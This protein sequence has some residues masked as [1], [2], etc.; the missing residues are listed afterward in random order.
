MSAISKAEAYN[1]AFLKEEN[2]AIFQ[3]FLRLNPKVGHHFN[4]QVEEECEVSGEDNKEQLQV[5]TEDVC[6]MFEMRR[7]SLSWALLKNEMMDHNTRNF[8]PKNS[9]E[10]EKEFQGNSRWVHDWNWSAETKRTVSAQKVLP[11]M[12]GTRLQMGHCCRR[13]VEAETCYLCI[14]VNNRFFTKCETT[15]I[16][17]HTS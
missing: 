10:C 8:W 14:V 11:S 6:L 17:P 13:A 16:G 15:K 9:S 1:E 4:R 5:N 12:Q 3:K 7:K 2:V